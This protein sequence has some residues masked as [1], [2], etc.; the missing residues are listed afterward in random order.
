MKTRN[1][2]LSDL[3]F[4]SDE[5]KNITLKDIKRRYRK[6]VLKYNVDN[7][8]N[9]SSTDK[10]RIILEA[11]EALSDNKYTDEPVVEE[12]IDIEQTAEVYNK[13][14]IDFLEKGSFEIN[15]KKSDNK[16]VIVDNYIINF[17]VS[18]LTKRKYL[19]INRDKLLKFTRNYDKR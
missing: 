13:V 14:L 4:S 9:N 5:I 8:K 6:L 17:N 3:E 15:L 18:K 7:Q 2:Y 16:V 10:Y 12:K 19:L 1:Q 11:Y